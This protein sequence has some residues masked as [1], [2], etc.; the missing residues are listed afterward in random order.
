M[1]TI[2]IK[3]NER[4]KAGKALKGL[5]ELFSAENKGVEIIS[6]KSLYNPEFVAK[7]KKSSK[8]KNGK[9]VTAETLWQDLGL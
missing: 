9:E 8:D 2:T 5:I 3:I 1:T 4:T 6:D 7:I